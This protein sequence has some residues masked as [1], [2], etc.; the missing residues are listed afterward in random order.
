MR[1]ARRTSGA[2]GDL[3]ARTKDEDAPRTVRELVARGREFLDRKGVASSRLETEILVAHALGCD[4]LHVFLELDRPVEGEEIVRAR[5]ALVR[6]GKGEPCA[7]ITGTREFYGRDFAVGPGALVPRPETELL[8]DLARERLADCR[9][10]E[11]DPPAVLDVGTGSGC[12]A[13]TLALEVPEAVVSATELSEAA[14][15]FARENARTRGAEVELLAG[16]GTAPVSGRRFDLVLSNP[17]YV[18]PASSGE[19]APEVRAFEP[20]EAL[21]APAGDPDHWVHRLVGDAELLEPGGTLLIELGYDQAERVR[22]W[23]DARGE[24]FTI[25]A[26]LAGIPRVLEVSR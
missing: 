11:S 20:A 4:R 25:H 3:T 14:L 1:R 13:I 24:T 15:A 9:S 16:N 2:K 21:F 10:G 8:V 17:P 7:Y 18:D 6:R 19:L 5:E 23:L 26:D 12:I 22:A